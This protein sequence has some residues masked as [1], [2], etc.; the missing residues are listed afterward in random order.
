MALC[1]SF[2]SWCRS[3]SLDGKPIDQWLCSRVNPRKSNSLA[4]IRLHSRWTFCYGSAIQFYQDIRSKGLILNCFYRDTWDWYVFHKL[5]CWWFYKYYPSRKQ[6]R[7]CYWQRDNLIIRWFQHD[8]QKDE[9]RNI[10]KHRIC[11][12]FLRCLLD[13]Y[14][15]NNLTNLPT[16]LGD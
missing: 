4:I 6:W 12:S 8:Q 2:Y 7:V 10:V 5:N 16:S 15:I 14:D 9:R 13:S 3:V 1:C 11:S